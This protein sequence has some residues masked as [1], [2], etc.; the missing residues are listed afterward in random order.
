MGLGEYLSTKA[1]N[2][3]MEVERKRQEWGLAHHR[4]VG[5]QGRGEGW[6][7]G[8]WMGGSWIGLGCKEM[9]RG[10]IGGWMG[11]DWIGLGSREGG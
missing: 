8:G 9:G 4:Q 2:D 3:Y 5:R 10:R 7:V 6:G 1:M 11:G